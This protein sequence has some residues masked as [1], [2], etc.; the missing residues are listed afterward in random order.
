MNQEQVKFNQLKRNIQILLEAFVSAFPFSE[1]EKSLIRMIGNMEANPTDCSVI[2][3]CLSRIMDKCGE[4]DLNAMEYEAK[5]L[6][7]RLDALAD[8]NDG[9]VVR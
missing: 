1:N 5:T 7:D 8:E 4:L 6:S 3:S 9:P 2:Q